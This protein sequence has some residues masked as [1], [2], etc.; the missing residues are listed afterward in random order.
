MF[1]LRVIT[2]VVLATAFLVMTDVVLDVSGKITPQELPR[3]SNFTGFPRSFTLPALKAW[4]QSCREGIKPWGL[5]ISTSH[6]KVPPSIPRLLKRAVNNLS[7]FQGNYLV[8]TIILMAYCLLTSPLLLLVVAASAVA[9]YMLSTRNNEKR[10]I[11]SGKEVSL[12]QQYAAVGICSLPLY[13]WA[14]VGQAVFWVVGASC[15]VIS[16]HAG[17][18]NIDE[19]ISQEDQLELLVQQ[20]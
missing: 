2:S 10:L 16:L 20:I 3:S 17:L 19:V 9:C 6:Y 11:I 4:F 5:F 7:Y 15:F 13:Y 14:G 1:L 8:I 12:N 18:F